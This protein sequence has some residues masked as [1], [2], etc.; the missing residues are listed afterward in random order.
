MKPAAQKARPKAEPTAPTPTATGRASTDTLLPAEHNAVSRLLSAHPRWRLAADSDLRL[1]ADAEDVSRL[2]GAYHPY[3]VRGDVNDDGTLDFV[4]AFVENARSASSSLF[5]IAVFCGVPGG[6]FADPT[7]LEQNVALE[8]GDLTID[9]DSIVI[10]PDLSQDTGRRYR[11]NSRKKEF[12]FV[13][14]SSDP[15]DPAPMSRA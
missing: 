8:N 4:V 7:L 2:Y 10:T 3:F 5:T 6:G 12:E 14:D 15:S 11:W 1:S 9:R 13:A